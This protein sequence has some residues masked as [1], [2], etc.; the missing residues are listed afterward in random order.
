MSSIQI[1]TLLGVPWFI[2][3]T[4]LKK[5]AKE[6]YC[7]GL[8]LAAAYSALESSRP[9]LFAGWVQVMEATGTLFAVITRD[10]PLL[11]YYL[12]CARYS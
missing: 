8:G 12:L 10:P 6:A 4:Q 5:G 7:W 9:S 3:Y 11:P 1:L 2:T